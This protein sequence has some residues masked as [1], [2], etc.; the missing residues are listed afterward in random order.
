MWSEVHSHTSG[1]VSHNQISFFAISSEKIIILL[2]EQV[3]LAYYESV[4]WL[5][6][7]S[8]DMRLKELKDRIIDVAA[9]ERN[10][11]LIIILGVFLAVSGLIFTVVVDSGLAHFGGI[12]VSGLGIFMTLFGFY[13]VVHYTHQYNALLKELG[14]TL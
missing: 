3:F 1:D 7:L 10:G 9:N 14:R 2:A 12:S 13:V 11:L 8:D 5:S 4:E 6:M